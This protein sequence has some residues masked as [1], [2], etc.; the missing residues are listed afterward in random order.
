MPIS[1]MA[2]VSNSD[3]AVDGGDARGQSDLDGACH[4]RLK[5]GWH[6]KP[7]ARAERLTT[8]CGARAAAQDR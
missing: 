3:S 5:R 6:S 2:V 1:S 4:T 7:D 8:E